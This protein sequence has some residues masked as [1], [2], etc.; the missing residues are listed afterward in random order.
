MMPFWTNPRLCRDMIIPYPVWPPKPAT[1][2]LMAKIAKWTPQRDTLSRYELA[3]P[4]LSPASDAYK[5]GQYLATCDIAEIADW[6]E[7]FAPLCYND[8]DDP[9][10]VLSNVLRMESESTDG[11][12][13]AGALIRLVAKM[14]GLNYPMP[15]IER[16]A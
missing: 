7:F 13:L 4:K 6:F 2:E 8:S 12:T 1:P 5:L 14:R 3:L 10:N 15:E 16:R 9:K 11:E